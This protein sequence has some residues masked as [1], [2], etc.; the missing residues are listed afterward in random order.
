MSTRQ[1]L[2]AGKQTL[3]EE[4]SIVPHTKHRLKRA[5][6]QAEQKLLDTNSELSFEKENDEDHTWKTL[7]G[8]SIETPEEVHR[9]WGEDLQTMKEL[10]KEF[11]IRIN[12]YYASL[13]EQKDDPIYK[14]V[15]PSKHELIKGCCVDDPLNE[16][17]DSPRAEHYASLP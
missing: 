17:R 16:E 8:N 2:A 7:L 4:V 11:N 14:Q 10:E 3:A 13:I 15:V 1:T 5:Q 6:R 12:P 9:I